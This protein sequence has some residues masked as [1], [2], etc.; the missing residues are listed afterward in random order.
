MIYLTKKFQ[1]AVDLTKKRNCCPSSTR[2]LGQQEAQKRAQHLCG[3]LA[4]VLSKPPVC[5]P[6]AVAAQRLHVRAGDTRLAAIELT[7]TAQPCG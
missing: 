3:S 7:L 4:L 2:L 1:R 6:V 5:L